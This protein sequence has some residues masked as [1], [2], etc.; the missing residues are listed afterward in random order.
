MRRPAAAKDLM[1]HGNIIAPALD[2]TDERSI[3]EA[4]AETLHSFGRI[5]VVLNNAGYA[6]LGPLEL[7]PV[8]RIRKQFEVNVFGPIRAL[9][10]VLPH[11]RARREGLVI[12]VSSI[13]GRVGLPLGSVYD[14]TKFAVEGLSEALR[15]ELAAIGV[16]VK[17]VEPA[18][19][20][21]SFGASIEFHLEGA[22]EEYA[23]VL[24]AMQQASVRFAEEAE[25]ASVVADVIWRAATDGT[26]TLRYPAGQAVTLLAERASMDDDAH[27]QLLRARFG[28]AAE[29]TTRATRVRLK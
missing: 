11:F 14:A 22:P 21:T 12:D 15:Y 9:Q 3:E 24:E 7:I 26:D 4:V 20:D 8:E 25:P 29:A 28:L 19:V 10:A 1:S 27:H 17:L 18:F 13:V 16:R 6:V 2:V 5:D 23:P